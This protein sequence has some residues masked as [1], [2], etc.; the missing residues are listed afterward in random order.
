MIADRLA[1]GL[2]YKALGPRIARAIEFLEGTDLFAI[3]DGRHDLDDSNVYALVQ[4]YTSKVP[5]DCKWEA[6]RLYADL[7]YVV[8]GEE[9]IG[10]G[11][12]DRFTRN[13]Y[14]ASKD[15]E[16]LT[17]DGDFVRVH[18]GGFVLLWPGEVHM[19]Q[20]AVDAPAPVKK[21]VVKI[22]MD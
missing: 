1:N 22:R 3:A 15:F 7:Q 17:G 11:P 20:V 21:V 14:D 13:G 16:A 5:A 19:P 8:A 18:A 2:R 12:I 4:R 9:R 6:H 10:Y